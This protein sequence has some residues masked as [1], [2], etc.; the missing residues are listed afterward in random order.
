VLAAVMAAAAIAASVTAGVLS[1][2]TPAGAI[3]GG[4]LVPQGSYR[5]AAKFTFTGIPRTD[6]TRYD[7]AC[8]G[9]LIAA[10]WVISA[11]HCFHDAARR[12]VN[13]RP[14]YGSSMV[15]IGRA[16]VNVGTGAVRSIVDVRQSPTNDI[17]LV[18]LSAPV[19]GI[20]PLALP[21]IA[22]KVGEVVRLAGYGATGS[23]NPTP[24]MVLRT[25]QFTV[26]AISI[27][28]VSVTGRAPAK[29]TSACLY[30]SGAPYFRDIR[31]ATL[32][33]VESSGPDCPHAQR[34]TTSRV[35]TVLAWLNQQL[36]R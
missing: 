25:G 3:A 35:D 1:G 30:D 17:A 4:T 12:R 16:N 34:E 24:S 33:S 8:S 21:K 27:P 36:R 32:V 13:G 10:Q 14:P 22:P 20:T 26:A 11:G 2:G 31:P 5:F 23:I 15:T 29:N 6:G 19:L 18:K 9:G 7:S 28:L